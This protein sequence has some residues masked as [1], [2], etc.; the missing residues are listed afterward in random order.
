[1]THMNVSELIARFETLGV[2]SE[3]RCL[4]SFLYSLTGVVRILW[5]QDKDFE[6]RARTLAHVS[7][8]N[9]YVLKRVIAIADKKEDTWF[10]VEHTWHSVYEHASPVPELQEW[11]ARLAGHILKIPGA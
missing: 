7:E 3:R 2:E 11:A 10:T 4:E 6:S 5:H 9:R 8:I 1:M